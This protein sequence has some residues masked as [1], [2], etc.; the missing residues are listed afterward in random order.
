[1]HSLLEKQPGDLQEDTTMHTPIDCLNGLL[2]GEISA[3]ETYSLALKKLDTSAFSPTLM[4]CQLA[5][6][7]RV[8]KLRDKIYAMGGKA[9]EDSGP[10]GSFAK[11]LEASA[12]TI[13]DKTS[14]ELLEEGEDHG[15]KVYRDEFVKCDDAGVRTLIQNELLPNQEQTHAEMSMLKKIVH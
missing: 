3:V 1:M 12:A 2:R 11:F 8:V 9:S 15:L 7:D 10:W 5:H 6:Q 14:I 13:G 4:K